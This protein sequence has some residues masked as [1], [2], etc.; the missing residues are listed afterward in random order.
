MG[1]ENTHKLSISEL[2]EVSG[3]ITPHWSGDATNISL[4]GGA[5]SA[6]G[7]NSAYRDGGTKI[8]GTSSV[9]V[10]KLKFGNGESHNNMP[11]YLVQ[12]V[13]VRAL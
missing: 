12:N 8:A 4:T 9:Q 3:T 10:I 11:P 7:N 6:T 1:G 2:P 5:F 13:I